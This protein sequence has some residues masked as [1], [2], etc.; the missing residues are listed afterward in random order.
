MS[1]VDPALKELVDAYART[2]QQY[3]EGD[4]RTLAAYMRIERYVDRLISD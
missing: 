2:L 3:G 4:A 1:N